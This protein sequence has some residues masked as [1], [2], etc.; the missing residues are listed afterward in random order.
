MHARRGGGDRR[1]RRPRHRRGADDQR[2]S[3]RRSRAL[4]ARRLCRG[5]ARRR[6]AGVAAGAGAERGG[7]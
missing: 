4:A 2:G 1:R 7:G 3:G 6:D 5:R